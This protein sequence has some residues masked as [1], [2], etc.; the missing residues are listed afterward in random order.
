[1]SHPVLLDLFAGAGGAAVGYALA[2]FHVIGVDIDPQPDYP[3]QFIQ[4]DVMDFDLG[5]LIS[6]SGAV[7]IHASPPCQAYSPLN[8][9]NK[10]PYPDL[11]E[12]V[13]ELLIDTTLP[14]IIENVPQAPL[15]NPILLC[16]TMFGLKL[17]RHRHFESNMALAAPPH[18]RHVARC[19]RNGYLPTPDAPFMTISGGK[20]SRA[21]REKA[22]EE[23]G[24]PWMKTVHD[25]SESVPPSYTTFT[26]GQLMAALRRGKAVA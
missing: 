17:Y 9:Y 7:A 8:A 20:H 12:P 16:G 14:F 23:M 25:V 26:G 5:A 3:F 18:P 10:L 19:T 15:L 21:W 24:T 1:M 6:N 11:V 4:R 13:R 22:C 2:G